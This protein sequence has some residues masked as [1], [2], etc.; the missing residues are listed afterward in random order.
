MAKDPGSHMG[1]IELGGRKY[2]LVPEIDRMEPFL[3]TTASLSDQW[4]SISSNG[5]LTA[6]RINSEH[7]IFFPWRTG[8]CA[9][10]C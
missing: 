1:L 5:G 8:A 3:A 10:R 2:C 6:G 4:L 9:P 7:T